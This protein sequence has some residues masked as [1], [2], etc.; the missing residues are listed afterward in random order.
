MPAPLTSLIVPSRNHHH[1]LDTLVNS[2]LRTLEGHRVELI[3]VDNGSDDPETLRWLDALPARVSGPVFESV[4]ILLDPAPFNYSRLN[5]RAAARARGEYLCLLNDD[6]EALGERDWLGP[7]IEHARLPANGCVGAKLLYP[8]DTIQHA[9]VMLGMG[10]VAGHPCKGMARDAAGHEG[11]LLDARRVSAVTGACLLVRRAVFEEVGGFDERLPIAWNDVDLCLRVDAAGYR[12]VW[13]PAAE[14][15]HHESLSRRRRG[16]PGRA[17]RRR[18]AA[19]VAFMH[20]RWGTRLARD[21][22]LD[23]LPAA[24]RRPA[25]AVT[26]RRRPLPRAVRARLSARLS[27][28]LARLRAAL[29]RRRA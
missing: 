18:H 20:A 24:V 16:R 29:S 14:L 11:Y 28:R 3:V 5:N 9:G 17:A 25:A 15:R 23:H 26:S 22:H 2:L 21:P 19:D 13:T 27:V 4:T 6:I 7:M 8:D 10:R 1:L 12:N